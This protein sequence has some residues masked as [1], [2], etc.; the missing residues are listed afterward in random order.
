[1][2]DFLADDNW[3]D[4]AAFLRMEDSQKQSEWA[5]Y[6]NVYETI[7]NSSLNVRSRSPAI[8]IRCARS[9]ALGEV[10]ETISRAS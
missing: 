5:F 2:V 8:Q 9:L 4:L 10:T 7:F 1:V 3:Q 6:I